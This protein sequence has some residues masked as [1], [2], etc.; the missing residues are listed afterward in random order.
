[1]IAS[2]IFLPHPPSAPQ[3]E[4]RGRCGNAEN[5]VRKQPSV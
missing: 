5:S 1:V 4:N 2:A 3:P